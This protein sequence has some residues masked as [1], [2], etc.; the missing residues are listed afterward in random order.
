MLADRHCSA[1]KGDIPRLEGQELED[2]VRQ[3]PAWT[4][5]QQHHLSRRFEFRDFASA[6]EF[7]NRVGSVAEEEGHHPDI[8]LAWGRVEIEIFTHKINGMSESDFILAARIDRA[9]APPDAGA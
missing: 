7:V 5:V 1:C 8:L 6:L 9:F 2:L 4:V 3:L